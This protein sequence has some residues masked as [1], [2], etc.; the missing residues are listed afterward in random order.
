MN[1]IVI[2]E[3]R[4]EQ[5]IFPTTSIERFDVRNIDMRDVE[6]IIVIFMRRYKESWST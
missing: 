3:L 4:H 1:D 5:Q 2:V 6:L